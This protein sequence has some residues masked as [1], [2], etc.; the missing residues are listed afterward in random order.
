MQTI[1]GAGG[2]IG[3]EL[4]KLLPQYTDKVRLVSRHP[5]AVNK[6]DLLFTCN[7]TNI[8]QVREAVRGSEIAYLVAGIEYSTKVWEENWHVIMENTIEACKESNVSLVFFDNVYMYDPLHIPHMTEETPVN[9]S[10]RKGAVRA[11]IAGK[12]MDDVKAGNLKALIARSADFY[13]PGI[14]GSIIMNGVY[15]N[16]NKGKRANWFC[17]SGYRH[18]ATFTPDA[19]L[20]TALLGNTESAYGQIWHVPT[21]TNPPTG[22][23]WIE[24]FSS[25]LQA[26]PRMLIASKPVV[27]I[28]GWFDPIL[29]EM[30]EMLYQYDRDYVFDSTK[31]TNFFGVEPTT[32]KRGVNR[33]V[34]QG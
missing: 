2:S 9:P 7:L 26:K 28:L 1:L 34:H 19:A 8:E 5:K 23:E 25:E 27:K 14:T 24:M 29:R 17:S 33:V 16:L 32:Y 30:V 20:A 15:E 10:S 4:A 12:L 21:A 6:T 11:R 18:S 22:R 3:R 31:F 13:G